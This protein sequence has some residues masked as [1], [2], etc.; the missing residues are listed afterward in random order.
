MKKICVDARMLHSGGIGTYLRT[1]LKNLKNPPFD[2]CLMVNRNTLKKLDEFVNNFNLIYLDAPIYSLK[3]QILFSFKIPKCDLFFSPHFNVPVFPIRAKKRLVTIHDMYHFAFFNKLTFLEKTYAQFIINKAIK[4]SDKIITVSEFSKKEILKYTK[5]DPRK[6]QVIHNAIDINVFKKTLDIEKTQKISK[7]GL[8]NKLSLPEKYFLFVGNLKPHKN[9][10]N[11]IKAFEIFINDYKDY[12]LVI[13]GS[14]KN[15]IN[16][17][18]L[19]QILINNKEMAGKVKFLDHVSSRDLPVIYQLAEAFVFPSLYEGFGY[20]PLEAMSVDCPVIA[21]SQGAILEIC[22]DAA[23]YIDPY[24]INDMSNAMK[25][26]VENKK[27]KRDLIEKGQIRVKSYTI[28]NFIK[29]HKSQIE[30]LL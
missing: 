25:E 8:A 11:L 24:N 21:S 13:V 30:A 16:P 18:D 20:P 14:G 22:K 28:E 23:Y 29:T 9:L 26:V 19:G 2:I 27:L 10:I 5:A 4:V 1:F 15:L 6:I 7:R 17:V 12:Y 3:E